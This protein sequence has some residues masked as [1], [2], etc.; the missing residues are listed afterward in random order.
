MGLL[1]SSGKS[2]LQRPSLS[3][4]SAAGKASLQLTGPEQTGAP[5]G[6]SW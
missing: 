2:L 1:L 6:I 3:L 4:E 5:E